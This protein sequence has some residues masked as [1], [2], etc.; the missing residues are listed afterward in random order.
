MPKKKFIDKKN[1]VSFHLV[2]RSQ[3][4]PL[5]ADENAP[6]RVLLPVNDQS[7]AKQP[8]KRKE[9]QQKFGVFFDDDYNYLQHLRTVDRTAEWVEIEKPENQKPKAPETSKLNL[10]SSVFASTVEEDVG[11]LN[12][13]APESGLRLDLDPDIV[14]AMDEDFDFDDPDNELE[15]DFMDLANADG[16][17]SEYYDDEDGEVSSNFSDEEMDEVGSMDGPQFTFKDEETKSRFTEYSMTSSVMRRNE[18]LTLLDNKFEKMFAGYDENE[19]GALDCDEIEGYVP[20]NDDILLQYADEFQNLNRKEQLDKEKVLTRTL[21]ALDKEDDD[22]LELVDIVMP[23][24]EKWDCESIL[25]TYSNIYNHPKLISEPRKIRIN[26][27]TGIPIDVLDS[28]KLTAKALSK[29]NQENE[30]FNSRGP[31][32]VAAQ[33]IISTLSTL[34]IRPKGENAEERKERKKLLK[35]YRRE[36]RIEKKV[37]TEAFKEEAKR[38]VKININNKNNVQGNRIL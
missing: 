12:K 16:S 11:L 36:R 4:D 6:Q 37:N 34:S 30:G 32:S 20:E 1:S 19:I 21:E 38:Q 5:T 8:E 25:S 18:Q 2:H 23:P 27:R 13:A 7:K 29:L 17:G 28:N 9:E 3:Q 14:A 22:D 24:K 10:P 26:P 35:D 15:D 33:S 31:T